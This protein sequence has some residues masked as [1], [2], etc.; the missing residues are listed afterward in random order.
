MPTVSEINEALQA[1]LPSVDAFERFADS[2]GRVIDRLK[3]LI[4]TLGSGSV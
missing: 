3:S 1:D 2:F 4:A